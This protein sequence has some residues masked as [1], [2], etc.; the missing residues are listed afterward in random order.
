MNQFAECTH[1]PDWMH[2]DPERA[3]RDGPFDGT[4]AFGFWT[5]SMLTRLVRE[6]QGSEYPDGVQFGFNYGFERVRLMEP[7]PVGARIRNHARLLEVR[8]KTPGRILVKTENRIEIEGTE[9]PALI[10]EWLT[11]LVVS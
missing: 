6:T 5:I 9:K 1:D 4:I 10:A 3:R 11:L 8:E 7:I 2:I